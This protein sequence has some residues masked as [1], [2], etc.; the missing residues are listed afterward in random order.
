[1]LLRPDDGYSENGR[2]RCRPLSGIQTIRPNIDVTLGRGSADLL[3][4]VNN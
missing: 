4:F 1:M 3:L 2:D